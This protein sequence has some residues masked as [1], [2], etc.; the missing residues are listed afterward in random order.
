MQIVYL[1]ACI[2]A[3]DAATS[4]VSGRQL[5]QQ[6]V[7]ATSTT[8]TTVAAAAGEARM[9]TA[10]GCRWPAAAAARP[11]VEWTTAIVR[12]TWKYTSASMT[13]ASRND[14]THAAWSETPCPVMSKFH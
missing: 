4:G 2:V 11:G 9:R 6:V 3:G 7:M 8:T 5:R 14:R 12:S 10:D 13:P 1:L